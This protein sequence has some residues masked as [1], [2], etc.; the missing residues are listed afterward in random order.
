MVFSNNFD[1]AADQNETFNL[2]A[3]VG[4]LI[5]NLGTPDQAE[6]KAVK[7]YLSEFL[8]DKRV[9]NMP[10]ISRYLLVNFIIVPRRLKTV[11]NLYKKIWQKDSPIREV[12]FELKGKLQDKFSDNKD[13]SRNAPKVFLEAAMTY[14]SPDIDGALSR[15]LKENVEKLLVLPLYPQFSATTTTPV[16][17]KVTEYLKQQKD[18]PALIFVKDY[19]LHQSYIGSLVRQIKQRW[20]DNP[21]PDCLLLSFHGIP[22]S[23]QLAGDPYIEQCHASAEAIKSGL[24]GEGVRILTTFQSRVTSEEWVKPYTEDT[25]RNLP[26]SGVKELEVMCPG[27]SADCLETLE[28]IGIENKHLFLENGGKNYFAYPCLNANDDHIL[29]FSQIIDQYL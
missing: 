29:H 11:T 1:S 7:R 2:N 18:I 23:Y 8:M 13:S 25:I 16:F 24:E 14:G 28:E 21:K 27:F 10:F 6:K 4:V 5:V 19:H 9:I 12:L 3:N 26:Q 17:E 22:I 20:Q 15:L